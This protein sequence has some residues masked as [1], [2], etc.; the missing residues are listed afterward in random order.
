MFWFCLVFKSPLLRLQQGGLC[1][2]SS[3]AR[4]RNLFMEGYSA[5]PTLH[6]SQSRGPWG[7][8][9]YFF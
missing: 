6:I 4:L 9:T 2:L 1:L 5:D 7:S 3:G 8:W